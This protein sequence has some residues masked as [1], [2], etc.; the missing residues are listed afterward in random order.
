MRVLARL[1][2]R[3]LDVNENEVKD[4]EL[5]ELKERCDVLEQ[6]VRT[7]TESHNKMFN[8]L[9]NSGT[10]G[11]RQHIAVEQKKTLKEFINEKENNK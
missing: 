11:E 6:T 7:L 3:C 8:Y 4:P 10:Q 5:L 9:K 2:T 1:R